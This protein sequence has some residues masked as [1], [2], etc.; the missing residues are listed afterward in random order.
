MLLKCLTRPCDGWTYPLVGNHF[1]RTPTRY[2]STSPSAKSGKE[3][4]P[5]AVAFTNRSNQVPSQYDE[6]TPNGMAIRI[7]RI[8]EYSISCSDT[9]NELPTSVDTLSTPDER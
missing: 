8:S 4:A 6:K 3:I 1:N 5:N 9:G 2:A 7:V